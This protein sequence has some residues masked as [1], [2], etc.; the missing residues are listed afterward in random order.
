MHE[1]PTT[2]GRRSRSTRLRRSLA[3][4]VVS[5]L[6]AVGVTVVTAAPAAAATPL[7]GASVWGLKSN[8]AGT[9]YA[10]Y[11]S[12]PVVS[13]TNLTDPCNLYRGAAN[14][15]SVVSWLQYNINQCYFTGGVRT[16]P[17][18]LS[19]MRNIYGNSFQRIAEDG[20]FGPMTENAVRAVQ[21][22]EGVTP[23]GWFGKNTRAAMEW[24]T[25]LGD[26][27]DCGD[28][29]IPLQRY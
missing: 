26:A 27:I 15:A 4:V 6:A 9:I 17:V 2:N 16:D 28:L 3:A 20:S 10:T 18:A 7:C 24:Q 23:D 22:S 29:V 1:Q 14:N 8:Y 11:T 21:T 13:S 5:L 19:Y 25:D 12:V